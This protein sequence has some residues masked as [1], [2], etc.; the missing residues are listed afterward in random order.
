M[1]LILLGL[2]GRVAKKTK[3][4]EKERLAARVEQ[5]EAA[6][7]TAKVVIPPEPPPPSAP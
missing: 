4:G 3:F 6:M 1:V 2:I 5:L 7:K